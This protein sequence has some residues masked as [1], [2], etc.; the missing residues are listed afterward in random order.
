MPTNGK[1]AAR[2][3]PLG[4]SPQARLWHNKS[5]RHLVLGVA[6]SAPPIASCHLGAV[7]PAA[8]SFCM[9]SKEVGA[10]AGLADRAWAAPPALFSERLATRSTACATAICAGRCGCSARRCCRR[11]CPAALALSESGVAA[12]PRSLRLS[13]ALAVPLLPS[14][15]RPS[16]RPCRACPALRTRGTV[17]AIIPL[18][19][20]HPAPWA[21]ASD[22]QLMGKVS[23]SAARR[24]MARNRCAMPC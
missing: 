13:R 11:R 5:Y 20:S 15:S 2:R 17:A 14:I 12:M 19:G 7:L 3:S 8:A 18:A 22:P 16:P 6:F 21:T 1:T 9:T 24:P 4:A 10:S 23:D